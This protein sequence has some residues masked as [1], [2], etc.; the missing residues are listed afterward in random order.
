[1]K[2]RNIN[3]S[4]CWEWTG[5]KQKGGYGIISFNGKSTTVIRVIMNILKDFDLD[6]PLDICHTCDNPRC[7]NPEHLFP[8]TRQYNITDSVVKQAIAEMRTKILMDVINR[9]KIK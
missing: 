6:S 4:D 9:E 2:Q 1:M 7:F 5:A 3:P 8:E